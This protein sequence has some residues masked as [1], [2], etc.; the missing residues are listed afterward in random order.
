MNVPAPAGQKA[1][2]SPTTIGGREYSGHALDRMQ[3]QG[4]T[5]S[6]VEGAIQT[7]SNPGKIP[8]TFAH[9]DSTNN[10]TVITNAATGRVV[11][12]DHGHIRQ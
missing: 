4:I 5:P 10:I 3:G 11:T 7:G 12:V 2:N 1:A 8:G 9:Y 6:V